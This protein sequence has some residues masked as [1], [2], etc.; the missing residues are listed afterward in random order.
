[1]QRLQICLEI[2][3]QARWD[4]FHSIPSPILD[5]FGS[6]MFLLAG[7][8]WGKPV[9]FDPYNLKHPRRDAAL[10][11]FAGPV[12]NA[13]MACVCAGL[14]RLFPDTFFVD[15]GTIFIWINV[16]L[17]IFN[18][19]PISPL[20]GFKVV[21]GLLSEEQAESW[22]SLERYG[23]IF[24]L[25]CILPFAGGRSMLEILVLPI[26]QTIASWMI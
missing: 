6:L 15:I 19:L 10:I 1:M 7:F 9:P 4:E 23:I 18:L 21:G 17:G 16:S 12:S 11:A 8:G 25:L 5:L 24:L 22:Y 20:D 26:I 2:Q 13:V 3:H 14:I